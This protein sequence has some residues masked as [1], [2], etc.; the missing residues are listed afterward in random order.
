MAIDRRHFMTGVLAAAALPATALR[1]ANDS[2]EPRLYAG[3]PL[4]KN[5]LARSFAAVDLALPPIKVSDGARKISLASLT[6]KIRIVTL[7]AE[8]CAPCLVEARDFAELRRRF[9]N[10]DFDIVTVL[11]GSI[12][13]LDHAGAVARLQKAGAGDLP[14]LVEERGGNQVMRRLALDPAVPQAKFGTLPCTLLVDRDG[15]VRGRARGAPITVDAKGTDRSS[16]GG[17]ARVP[18]ELT[19]AEKAALLDGTVRSAWASPA[20]DAF[21]TALRDGLPR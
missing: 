10:A 11:T 2:P 18:R 5:R 15:R 4:A 16:P 21:V 14:V 19:Q 7:W 8:W 3:T 1:A 12:A 9:A 20:G 6:G 17:A 13:K